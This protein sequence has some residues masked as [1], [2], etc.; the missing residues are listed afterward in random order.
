MIIIHYLR[1]ESGHVESGNDGGETKGEATRTFL[2][3][4]WGFAGEDISTI[5]L[6][7]GGSSSVTAGS[8]GFT[9]SWGEI[10]A[11]GTFLS[12]GIGGIIV[13]ASN[14]GGDGRRRAIAANFIF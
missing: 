9:L 8:D 7:G 14:L 5:V 6:N 3:D 13:G 10:S 4:N 11:A 2:G 12:A 1:S